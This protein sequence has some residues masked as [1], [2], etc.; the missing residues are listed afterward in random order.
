MVQNTAV[1]VN[2]APLS[3]TSLILIGFL[4]YNQQQQGLSSEF[5]VATGKIPL[6]PDN[7]SPVSNPQALSVFD[8]NR[9][10]NFNELTNFENAPPE[11]K[12]QIERL[13]DKAEK[14]FSE[15]GVE[16]FLDDNVITREELLIAGAKR[17]NLSLAENPNMLE[18]I[19]EET[20]NKAQELVDRYKLQDFAEKHGIN[21]LDDGMIA[22][23]IAIQSVKFTSKIN[24]GLGFNPDGTTM[25]EISPAQQAPQ[26]ETI[27]TNP[28]SN[29]FQF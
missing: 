19:D 3:D 26:I 11:T 7:I 13:L 14:G 5:S 6:I 18:N 2:E 25:P 16:K 9:D 8:Q 1:H 21:G 15:L 27:S 22:R 29:D 17:G 12:Q 20:Y 10:I 28:A 24:E 23:G 4:H